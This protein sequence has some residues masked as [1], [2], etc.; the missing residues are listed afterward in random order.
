MQKLIAAVVLALVPCAA[1]VAGC[2]QNEQ[3][4]SFPKGPEVKSL[5]RKPVAIGT[6]P[7]APSVP[8][9]IDPEVLATPD[10]PTFARI[11][12]VMDRE[13]QLASRYSQP[14]LFVLPREDFHDVAVADGAVPTPE[15]SLAAV[16][17]A[18]TAREFWSR[19]PASMSAIADNFPTFA[20]GDISAMAPPAPPAA[21]MVVEQAAPLESIPGLFMGG[22]EP[23]PSVWERPLSLAVPAP[24]DA[25]PAPA[26]L[27]AETGSGSLLTLRESFASFPTPPAAAA[28][29]FPAARTGGRLA[30]LL[31]KDDVRQALAP[32]PDI[33]ALA[34]KTGEAK[35]SGTTPADLA[36]A[37]AA[38]DWTPSWKDAAAASGVAREV[39]MS[40]FWEKPQAK[41]AAGLPSEE[42]DAPV[43]SPMK[44]PSALSL[45]EARPLLRPPEKIT[46]QPRDQTTS[47]ARAELDR[48]DSA[49]DVPPLRF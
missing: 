2:R 49:V 23:T 9:V 40:D 30:E 27:A 13:A 28:P 21:P 6:T 7:N 34:G 17:P 11:R 15:P 25:N 31:Q 48:I 45:P 47:R 43:V 20:G 10:Q 33:S 26:S 18:L 16:P 4:K 35:A 19:P 44:V 38:L 41:F 29:P 3:A 24:A 12:A 32:L 36:A 14:G 22:A 37:V 46:L 5:A 8:A 39:Y 1:W 42:V